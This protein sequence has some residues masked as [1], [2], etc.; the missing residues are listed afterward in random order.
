MPS[1][2]FDFAVIT[3][4]AR[5]FLEGAIIIGQYRTIILRG[6][7]LA[8]GI[9]RSDALYEITLSA[10]AA[11]A[12]ALLV[13]AAVAIPLAILSNNFDTTTSNIIEAVSKIVAALSLLQLSLKIPRFL[14]VYGSCKKAAPDKGETTTSSSSAADATAAAT[15]ADTSDK[16]TLQSIRFNVAWNIWREVA[17]CGVFLIPSFLSGENL[18]VIPLSALVGSFVGAFLGVGL[19]VANARFKNKTG[20]T[21]FAVLLLVFLSAGLFTNGCHKLE[22]EIGSTKTVWE[23]QGDFWSVDRLP[24]TIFKPFGYN[25]SRTV[26]EIVCFWGCLLLSAALHYRKYRI[27]PKISE[28]DGIMVRQSTSENKS[29]LNDP[30]LETLEMGETTLGETSTTVVDVEAATPI[31]LRN[32][33]EP[34]ESIVGHRLTL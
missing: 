20:L 15:A 10:I 19:Y 11:T 4:F 23:L 18:G 1:H 5:E 26:L 25:D 17:E 28:T 2:L 8:P 29:S 30:D 32:G 16:L 9:R 22:M 33:A 14:G 34:E 21:V 31:H 7:S 12:L 13:I 24:M 27:S 6:N 3:I